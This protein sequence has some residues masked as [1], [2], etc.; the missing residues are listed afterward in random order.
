MLWPRYIC[1]I[2]DTQVQT[3]LL[4]EQLN[5]RKKVS[6]QRIEPWP[7]TRLHCWILQTNPGR[8]EEEPQNTNR[9]KKS[10]RQIKAT[11][12]SSLFFT[13]MIAKLEG[14]NV[15][16]GKKQGPNAEPQQ[17]MEASINNESITTEPPP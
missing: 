4:I 15:K 6:N 5:V 17:T 2:L 3:H 14:H 16:N 11:T 7:G 9:F 10:G 12:C 13:N 8:R 1:N